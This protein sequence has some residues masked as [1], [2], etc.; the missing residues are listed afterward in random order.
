MTTKEDVTDQQSTA[1]T[2][3]ELEQLKEVFIRSKSIII[4][5]QIL[6]NRD[7]HQS[8][9]DYLSKER[10]LNVLEDVLSALP[11]ARVFEHKKMLDI[12]IKSNTLNENRLR[13]YLVRYTSS[14]ELSK[15]LLEGYFKAIN[16]EK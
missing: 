4:V 2:F 12:L 14:E 5:Y 16:E 9:W 7:I 1:F 13:D 3:E 6:Q 15:Y 10:H 8:I 11:K